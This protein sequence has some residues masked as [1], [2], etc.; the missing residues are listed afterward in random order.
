[1]KDVRLDE[2]CFS[3]LGAE[4]LPPGFPEDSSLLFD[5][6]RNK[7]QKKE[8]KINK[9]VKRSKTAWANIEEG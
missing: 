2:S 9:K 5:F 6:M 7:K 8:K 1:M 3:A 4:L